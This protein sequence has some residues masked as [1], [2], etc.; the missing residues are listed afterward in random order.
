MK[1][2]APAQSKDFKEIW[3][4]QSEMKISDEAW[5]FTFHNWDNPKDCKQ[6]RIYKSCFVCD[7]LKQPNYP[8]YVRGPKGEIIHTDKDGRK[9]K[10]SN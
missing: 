7:Q 2:R 1:K 10:S 8:G 4:T 5:D 6:N 9:I 3:N